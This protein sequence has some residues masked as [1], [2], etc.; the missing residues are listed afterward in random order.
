[1]LKALIALAMTVTAALGSVQPSEAQP[2]PL[3]PTMIISAQPTSTVAPRLAEPHAD[4]DNAAG[5]RHYDEAGQLLLSDDWWE[6]ALRMQA[7]YA[8]SG[9]ASATP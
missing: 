8:A 9:E 4:V 2:A 1:M 6:Y 5:S 7:E 3:E